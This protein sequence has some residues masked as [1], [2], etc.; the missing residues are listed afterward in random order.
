MSSKLAL[1]PLTGMPPDVQAAFRAVAAWAKSSGAASGS[2]QKT[3]LVQ[4]PQ[5]TQ[6]VMVGSPGAR[7]A[8]SLSAFSPEV[9]TIKNESIIRSIFSNSALVEPIQ[10]NASVVFQSGTSTTGVGIG[11]GGIIGKNN[12]YAYAGYDG[13]TFGISAE[14]G[15]FFF[16]PQVNDP[17]PARKQ[18][19]FD[20][21]TGVFQFGSDIV[22]KRSSGSLQTL[23]DIASASGY[24]STDLQADLAAG[25]GTILAGQ[26][27]NYRM[28]VDTTG[29]KVVLYHKDAVF[30]GTAAAGSN[31]PA[32]GITA[33][34]IAMGYNRSSDGAWVDSVAIDS[35]GNASFAGTITA[36]SIISVSATCNGT[37]MGTVVSNAANGASAYSSLS[38]KLDKNASYVMGASSEFQTSGYAGGNGMMF[39]NNG[40]IARSGGVNKFVIASNGDATFSG[41]LSAASG[42]FAGNISTS[43]YV[44]AT[45]STSS[46]GYYGAIIGDSGTSMLHSGVMGIGHGANPGVRAYNVDGAGNGVD[47]YSSQGVGVHGYSGSS[48]GVQ[49]DASSASN[50]G[51]IAYGYGAG[52]AINI[53][54]ALKWGSYIYSAPNGSTTT[55]LCANG[56][57]STPTASASWGGITGTLSSQTDLNNALAGKLST[58]GTAANSSALGG[59]SVASFPIYKSVS[60][61]SG[62]AT[63]RVYVNWGGT[64]L[65]LLATL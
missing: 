45:G 59:Y 9:P 36:N 10:L 30:K 61:Y 28:H 62:G 7:P 15:S 52:Q 23:E 53:D 38:N 26:G 12:A 64:Y 11:A 24:T 27:G 1:P 55:Y 37:S 4:A 14:D 48:S 21:G 46:A 50:Y 3:A 51:V 25:V 47:G 39:S 6:R 40:I 29:A 56:T 49:G 60:A 22:V 54:R 65:Y 31:K 13:Y 18:I 16:G 34:G 8:S 43:G 41:S 42:S 20:V 58:S 32:L 19:I 63:Y 2:D 33:A 17:D 44:I 57:W 5:Q 35:S